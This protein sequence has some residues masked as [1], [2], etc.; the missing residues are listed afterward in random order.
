VS[1]RPSL[2]VLASDAVCALGGAV[3][4]VLACVPWYGPLAK[5]L[6]VRI[7]AVAHLETYIGFLLATLAAV[8]GVLAALAA[9]KLLDRSGRRWLAPAL[10]LAVVAAVGA[11]HARWLVGAAPAFVVVASPLLVTGRLRP[12]P[13]RSSERASALVCIASEAACIAVGAWLPCAEWYPALLLPAMLVVAGV[14]ACLAALH[15]SD[16]VRW[17]VVIAGL[18]AVLLPFFGLARQ[19][20]IVPALVVTLLAAA[21]LAALPRWPALEARALRWARAHA[22]LL[23]MPALVLV[24]VLPWRFRDMGVADHAGHEGQHLGWINSISF[25]KLMMADA[26]FTYGPAREYALAALAWSMGGL[27]LEHVRLAHVVVNI[28]G[29][30]CLFAAMRRVCAGQIHALL[31]GLA[32]LVTHSALA[33]FVVYTKT[34]S[35][36]W[37]DASRAGLATLSV[38]VAL[39][40]RLDASPGSRHRLLG[41]GALAA[42]SILYSHDFGVL[43]VIATLVGLTSEVLVARAKLPVRARVRATLRASA[44]YGAGLAVVLVPF[45]GVYAARGR[46]VALLRGYAWTVQV[47]GGTVAFPGKDWRFGDALDSLAAATRLT[48]QDTAIPSRALDYVLGPA[49]PVLGLCH[50]AVALVRRRFAQRTTVILAL[51]V[52]AAGAVHHSLLCADAW[53]VANATTPGL[54]LLTALG[55][56][57]RRLVVRWPD[58]RTLALGVVGVSALGVLWLANGGMVPINARLARIAAGDERPSK[59]DPYVYPDLPRVGDV[60]I[61]DQHTKVARYVR[62]HS[63]PEDPVF[64]TTWMLGGGAEAFLSERRNPTSFDKPDEVV[65]RGQQAQALH[66]LEATPPVLIVGSF[67][68]YLGDDAGALI[69]T[70]WVVTTTDPVEVRRHRE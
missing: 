21:T 34:Y 64:C 5:I 62:E 56:G 60:G 36:G 3:A 31:L 6:R 7:G 8:T 28:V 25:G 66:D 27:T 48:E 39:T 26:G 15:A 50:V 65:T 42:L 11:H 16:E 63:A 18:P 59:G 46:L 51:A 54:V 68:D 49:I 32:L 61:G 33:C 53:H 70:R 37:A 44:A 10:V 40:R 69:R 24:L 23:A 12:V 55:A 13:W 47:S 67:F 9:R 19:P 4:S 57:G 29:L 45:L 35:F 38:V 20:T 2:S 41:A 30:G 43:A 1:R 14:A 17:R 52:L 22:T 58:G